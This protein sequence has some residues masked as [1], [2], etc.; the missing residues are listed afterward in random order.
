M[1][2]QSAGKARDKLQERVTLE[3]NDLFKTTR[4]KATD[5][6]IGGTAWNIY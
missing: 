2:T 5:R 1:Y 4:Q 3:L 6:Q